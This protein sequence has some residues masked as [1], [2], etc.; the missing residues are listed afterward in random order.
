[1]LKDFIVNQYLILDSDQISLPVFIKFK[2]QYNLNG[3]QF[4]SSHLKMFMQPARHKCAAGCLVLKC[5]AAG[6]H[7]H[8][9]L[10]AHCSAL[11]ATLHYSTRCIRVCARAI[12]TF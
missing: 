10:C 11:P 2:V 9:G 8:I 1:M 7:F 12:F 3:N 6:W 5:L 4:E